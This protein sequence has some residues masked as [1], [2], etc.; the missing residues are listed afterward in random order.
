MK[1]GGKD[2]AKTILQKTSASGDR[3]YADWAKRLLTDM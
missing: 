3:Y 1:T 2:E